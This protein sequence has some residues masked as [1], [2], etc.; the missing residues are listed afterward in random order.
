M[1]GKARRLDRVP[2]RSTGSVTATVC[3]HVGMQIWFLPRQLMSPSGSLN[4]WSVQFPGEPRVGTGRQCKN[5]GASEDQDQERQLV[6]RASGTPW[7]SCAGGITC[8][9]PLFSFPVTWLVPPGRAQGPGATAPAFLLGPLPAPV[10]LSGRLNPRSR[11]RNKQIN[12]F[13]GACH[14]EDASS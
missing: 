8:L 14:R 6:P 2:P 11:S 13:S 12:P 9:L 4:T 3:P 1:V 5:P 7:T 10:S